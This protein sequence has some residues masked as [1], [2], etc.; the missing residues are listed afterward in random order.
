MRYLCLL[1]VALGALP[2]AV[3]E[4]PIVPK[5]NPEA[6]CPALGKCPE[7]PQTRRPHALW[8]AGL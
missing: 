3:Q 4:R 6:F 2:L 1:A 5:V 7:K 8:S